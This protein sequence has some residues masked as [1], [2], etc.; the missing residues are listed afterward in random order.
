MRQEMRIVQEVDIV[1][2]D[3]GGNVYKLATDRMQVKFL[4]LLGH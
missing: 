3:A 2:V 4:G 1:L